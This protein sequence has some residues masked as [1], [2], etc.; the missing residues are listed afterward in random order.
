MSNHC[1]DCGT[2][3]VTYRVSF[4]WG[5]TTSHE[6]GIVPQELT[7][8]ISPHH[9]CMKGTQTKPSRCVALLGEIGHKVSCSIY[10]QR[11]STC[12]EFEAGTEACN[13]ARLQHGLSMLEIS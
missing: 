1:L 13:K 11:S 8:A 9:V 4:Y 2:C 12:R 5:E 10:E 3:C 7:K 6:K